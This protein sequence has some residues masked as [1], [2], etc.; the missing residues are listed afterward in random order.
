M[1]DGVLVEVLDGGCNLLD[2]GSYLIFWENFVFFQMSK[3][4]APFHVLK[5]EID[6]GSIIEMCVQGEDILMVQ[7][8]LQLQLEDKLIYHQ[9]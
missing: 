6:V 7:K 9:M 2:F 3:Q 5:N 8:C 1:S 4:C